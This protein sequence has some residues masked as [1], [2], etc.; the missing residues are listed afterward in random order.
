MKISTR[1]VIGV[2]AVSAAISVGFLISGFLI[3]D[4]TERE[5]LALTAQ[6]KAAAA[7]SLLQSSQAPLKRHGLTIGRE[8][9]AI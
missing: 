7:Q 6:N 1:V 4:R 9:A 5:F 2:V 3:L 8:R